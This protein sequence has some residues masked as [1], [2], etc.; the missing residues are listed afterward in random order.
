MTTRA[1]VLVW[2]AIRILAVLVAAGLVLFDAPTLVRTIYAGPVLVLVA[3]DATRRL[4]GGRDPIQQGDR[5]LNT[6]LTVILGLVATLG[7]VLLVNATGQPLTTGLLTVALTGLTII[8]VIAAFGSTLGRRAVEPP[9]RPSLRSSV[10]VGVG[11]LLSAAL[12][13]GAVAGARALRPVH[14]QQYAMLA[15][16]QAERFD[17]SP[18]QTQPGAPVRIGLGLTSYDST[19]P[20]T[21]PNLEVAVGDSPATSLRSRWFGV[22]SDDPFDNGSTNERRGTISFAAPRTAGLYRIRITMPD[23]VSG[24]PLLLTTDLRVPG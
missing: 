7:V 8:A 20:A 12:L 9:G 18:L 17:E 11:V 23:P 3:G 6:S 13:V 16:T 2:P 22:L 24:E 19:L 21:T 5:L 10:Q 4:L 1:R 15:F 14:E